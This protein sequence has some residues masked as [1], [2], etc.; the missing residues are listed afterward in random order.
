MIRTR[1]W[2]AV[3]PSLLAAVLLT[4]SCSTRDE[5]ATRTTSSETDT[6]SH[7]KPG[8][9]SDRPAQPGDQPIASAAL[10]EAT[11]K[12]TDK[13]PGKTS[14]TPATAVT[15]SAR[16]VE[17]AADPGG[18]AGKALWLRRM[19]SMGKD[20]ARGVA[21]DHQG[22]VALTGYYSDGADLGDGSSVAAQNVDVF[23]AKYGPG[24]DQVW[25]A[26]AG[27]KGEDVGNAV[28]FDPQG[29]VIIVGLFTDRVAIGQTILAGAGSDDAF[30]AKFG[31]DGTV[32]WARQL[33]GIDS[34]AAYHVAA[35]SS[36]IV[37][38]GSFKGSMRAA[39]VTLTSKG[40]EDIF[41]LALDPDGDLR[42]IKQ[43][44]YRYKDYGQRVAIDSRGNIVL[45]TEF[46]GQ[47]AFGGPTLQ[48]R[49]NRDLALVKLDGQGRH[50]WSRRYGSLFD[51]LGLGL[52]VD[53]AGNIAITGSFDNE[54]D[55]G[56]DKLSSQGESDIFVARFDPSGAHL[57]SRAYGSA[58]Q[59]VGIAIAADV[60]GNVIAGGWFWNK[61]DFGGGALESANHNKDGFLIKL[62]VNGEHLWS[63]RLGDRDHDQVRGL[64][65]ARDGRVA[66]CGIFR[67]TLKMGNQTVQSAR[68]S[69][70]RAP[71]PDAFVALFGR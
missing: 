63:Q 61:V 46:T 21:V 23:V 1:P 5:K 37:V 62:S 67:F 65:A 12:G 58:R 35:S 50:I 20:S 55:F 54:I 30:I 4:T 2:I 49:G 45:L 71:P 38:T 42:W 32:L 13:T 48:A 36:S 17:L 39:D 25:S 40:N 26:H 14:E 3:L 33:G 51:E 19:G 11:D 68:K 59:D 18:S 56:G 64:A 34:D 57:W 16:R 44:G 66:A 15:P 10:A 7:T 41:L 47:I 29:N 31:P 43:F 9:S 60:Y 8:S 27:G 22:N 6:E 52:A 69:Q 28:A 24:G 53:P 70:D